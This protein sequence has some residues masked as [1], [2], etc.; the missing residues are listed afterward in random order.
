MWSL[1]YIG[2]L[3]IILL[4]GYVICVA[5]IN[6]LHLE[7]HPFT[8]RKKQLLSG[9]RPPK[10]LWWPNGPLMYLGADFGHSKGPWAASGRLKVDSS[11]RKKGRTC[12]WSW[13]ILGTLATYKIYH[14]VVA[15]RHIPEQCCTN[16]LILLLS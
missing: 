12:R 3:S 1:I 7:V 5:K 16:G 11:L 14:N 10:D 4:H 6:Q 13:L 9:H 2:W 15:L 8:L